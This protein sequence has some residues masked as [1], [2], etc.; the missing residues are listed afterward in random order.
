MKTNDTAQISFTNCRAGIGAGRPSRGSA[1]L[2]G[3]Q[4]RTVERRA[5]PKAADAKAAQPSANSLTAKAAKAP[6]GTGEGIQIHGQW[7]IEIRNRD[8][9][10][11]RHVEFENALVDDGPALLTAAARPA[12]PW[13][14]RGRWPSAATQGPCGSGIRLLDCDAM[15]L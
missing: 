9:S 10:V 5:A 7:T 15:Q 3:E 13:R 1:G 11:A 8:G 14:A 6:R 2:G 12:L 4:L